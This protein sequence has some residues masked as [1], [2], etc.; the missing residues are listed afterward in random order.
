MVQNKSPRKNKSPTL[1]F[2]VLHQGPPPTSTAAELEVRSHMGALCRAPPLSRRHTRTRTCAH[3]QPPA[4]VTPAVAS[5]ITLQ[6]T[7][8]DNP[9][10]CSPRQGLIWRLGF[11]LRMRALPKNESRQKTS[12]PASGVGAR[13]GVP[14]ASQVA[15]RSASYS[16]LRAHTRQLPQ[17]STSHC[18]TPREKPFQPFVALKQT[19]HQPSAAGRPH[20]N[21][22]QHAAW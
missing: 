15:S 11:L 10:Q 7:G 14:G 18:R 4:A 8:H 1:A 17:G 20:D 9:L 16:A 2:Q 21:S 22:L 12:S 6:S 13:N 3:M 19:P 5:Q